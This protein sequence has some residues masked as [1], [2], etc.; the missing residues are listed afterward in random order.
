MLVE[1][2]MVFISFLVVLCPLK[3]FYSTFGMLL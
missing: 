1:I 2:W 3:I